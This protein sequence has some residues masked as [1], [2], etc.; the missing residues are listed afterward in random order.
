M[1]DWRA[2]YYRAISTVDLEISRYKAALRRSIDADNELRAHGFKTSKKMRDQ[3]R[4]TRAFDRIMIKALS[5]LRR[6]MRKR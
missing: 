5:Q 4:G 1:I 3:V 2:K 6:E